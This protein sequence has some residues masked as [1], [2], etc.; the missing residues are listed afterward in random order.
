[1]DIPGRSEFIKMAEPC[2][3]MGFSIY[4]NVNGEVFPCSFLEDEQGYKGIP[5]NTI[6]N[7]LKEIWFNPMARKFRADLAK[8]DR[9]CPHYN[10]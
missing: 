9:S 5:M 10:I 3:S 7:F 8:N 1:M 4:I 6:N 2:E